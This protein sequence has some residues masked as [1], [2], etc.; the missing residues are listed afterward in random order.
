MRACVLCVEYA[1]NNMYVVYCL[2]D[3]NTDDG[4]NYCSRKQRD[5][6]FEMKIDSRFMMIIVVTRRDQSIL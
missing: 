1:Y 5:Y 6:T 2:Y 4:A 3:M